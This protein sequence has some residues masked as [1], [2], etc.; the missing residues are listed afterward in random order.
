MS[1]AAGGAEA[2]DE[3]DPQSVAVAVLDRAGVIVEV[4]EAW[5]AFA[6]ENGGDPARTGI[7][8]SYLAVCES[9]T[10]DPG[11]ARVAAAI[12][13]ACAGELTVPV[14][15]RIPGDAP[16]RPRSFDVSVSSRYAS[17]GVCVGATVTL[18]PTVEDARPVPTVPDGSARSS[19]ELSFPDGPRLQLEEAIGLL[20]DHAESVL[21][22]QGR[23][24]ALLRASTSVAS[25]LSMAVVLRQIVSAA[26]ELVGARSAALGVVGHDG[27]PAQFIAEGPDV[28]MVERMA[29]WPGGGV[30]P[31]TVLRYPQ[32]HLPVDMPGPPAGAGDPGV[33]PPPDSLLV[34]PIR[35]RDRVF[36]TLYLIE[37]LRGEFT[38]EDEQLVAAF[39]SA[40]SSA[41]ENARLYQETEQ[42]RKWLAAS[43]EVT[44]QLFAG[45]SDQHL[46]LVVR[47][48]A[49]GA[50]AD[51]ANLVLSTGEG[52]SRQWSVKAAVGLLADRVMGAPVDVET[53]V[54]Q[55][56]LSGKPVLLEDY[57]S[58]VGD[59]GLYGFQDSGIVVGSMVCAPL[60][61]Q[62]EVVGVMSVG[63]VA[64]HG[65]FTETD[66]EQLAVFTGHAGRALELAQ[67][68]DTHAALT[69]MEDHERIAADLHDHV[70]REL[71]TI[72]IGLQGLVHR[73]PGIEDKRKVLGY[74]DGIDHV[75]ARI[76]ATVFEL[77]D[78]RPSAEGDA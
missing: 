17:D 43:A 30:A 66:M 31:D 5:S 42:N 50:G 49:K 51:L 35:I 56:I 23:L 76:R 1:R 72:G 57:A 32:H 3:T 53:A 9:A 34:A 69:R 67:A 52:D 45:T 61:V 36:G 48:A 59:G 64:G 4:N 27:A 21:K 41:I 33:D 55:V 15:V 8:A 16:D 25:D 11:A 26:R 18:T 2:L 68:R 58:Q 70:I 20:K 24:R 78:G 14:T 77:K 73:V 75:I 13:A 54:G 6:R 40:A 46:E 63:R 39:A 74:A 38:A 44:Q 7:G 47:F 28:G 22:A 19:P 60:L 65:S 37:S 10:G 71:F 29:V 62:N 12:R